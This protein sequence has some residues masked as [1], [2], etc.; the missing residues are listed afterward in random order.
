[1]FSHFR[2]FLIF[3]PIFEYKIRARSRAKA[4]DRAPKERTNERIETTVK[5][6][7]VGGQVL[8]FFCLDLWIKFGKMI[9]KV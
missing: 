5:L 3:L 6:Y 2:G 9:E 7:I 4:S 1:N 8:R